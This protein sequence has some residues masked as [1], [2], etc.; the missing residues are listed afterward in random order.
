ME[1]VFGLHTSRVEIALP[2]GNRRGG[3]AS[4]RR[5]ARE[6]PLEDARPNSKGGKYYIFRHCVPTH[7]APQQSRSGLTRSAPSRQ[8]GRNRFAPNSGHRK[9]ELLQ[10][11]L[12]MSAL[13]GRAD[14]SVA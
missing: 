3:I 10:Q 14:D 11:T 4:A 9:S 5:P 6:G 13:R 2:F 8:Q 12:T 7:V 1:A